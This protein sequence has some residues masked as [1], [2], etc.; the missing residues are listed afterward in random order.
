MPMAEASSI[1][2]VAPMLVTLLGVFLLK[3]K[4]SRPMGGRGA[5]FIGVLIIIV[6]AARIFLG[7]Q[8]RPRTAASFAPIRS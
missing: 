2:F 6:R 7:G 3:E 5:G 8:C 4:S 1:S